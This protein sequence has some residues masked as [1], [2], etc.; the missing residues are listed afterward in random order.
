MRRYGVTGLAV[1]VERREW[2]VVAL[3]LLLGVAEA[4]SRLPPESLAELLDLLGGA[5]VETEL[6]H[7]G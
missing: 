1:A 3:Y 4:A 2:Q 7:G 5:P 6:G